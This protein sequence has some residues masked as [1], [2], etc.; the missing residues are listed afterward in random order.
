MAQRWD[1]TKGVPPIPPQHP[2]VSPHRARAAW[3]RTAP[4]APLGARGAPARPAVALAGFGGPWGPGGDGPGVKWQGS[5]SRC[6]SQTSAHTRAHACTH[7]CTRGPMAQPRLPLPCF[8]IRAPWG[9]R[10][11]LWV[12]IC[13]LQGAH[14]ICR[15]L[16]HLFW[17]A[18]PICRMLIYHFW[19]A[20]PALWV[21]ISS[22][23]CSPHS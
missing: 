10:P 5:D 13:H 17:G 6:H 23:G 3:P 2:L 1:S 16:I 14:P 4:G 18:H 11:A 12:L 15:V 20:R 8:P 22:L 21:L 9:A 19:D 7:A